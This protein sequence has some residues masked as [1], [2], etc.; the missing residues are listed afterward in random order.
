M[1]NGNLTA[2]SPQN[3]SELFATFFE[4]VYDDDD[5][6]GRID[7]SVTSNGGFSTLSFSISDIETALAGLDVSKGPGDDGIPPSFIKRCADG[8]K[9]PLLHIFNLSLSKGLFP[10]KWKDSYLIPIFKSGKRNEVGN[11]RGVAILSCFA[12]LFEVITYGYIFFAIK[13]SLPTNQHGFVSGRSTVTNLIEFTSFVLNSMESGCQVDSIYTDFSKAFDK[14]NHRL[15]LLKLTCLGF[16]GNFLNWIASYLTGRCQYVKIGN[17]RSRLFPVKSGVPQGSHLGPLLFI[18]FLY[19]VN[20]CFKSVRFL[21]YADD[22]KIYFQVRNSSDYIRAQTELDKFSQW[23]S[24]N[25]MSLNLSKC[26]TI[27]F[28]RSTTVHN[29]DYRLSGS[30]LDR[31]ETITDL[32][33]VLDTKLTFSSHVDAIV[34]K[35]S[36]RLGFIK[37]IGK[38]FRD[39]Y[40][41]KT[42]FNSYVRSKLE[43]ASVIWNPYYRTHSDRIESVQRRFMRFALRFLRWNNNSPLPPYCQ[44]CRLID[45]E[46]LNVRRRVACV[47]FVHDVLSNKYDC[48]VVL[49]NMSFL[50]YRRNVRSRVMFREDQH[51]TNYGANEPLNGAIRVF[52]RFSNIYEHG[53][54]RGGFRNEVRRTLLSDPC[55]CC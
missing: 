55:T 51:R 18:L 45:V 48:P 43:Y 35:A 37:R 42:L 30:T 28:T 33:V 23:C 19:D 11:Y 1:K 32:G 21:L 41:L 54:G 34:N 53:G 16:G 10:S 12:K 29:F 6:G 38:E 49:S 15:L 3:V 24:D 40:A 27:S 52:N 2:D 14:V 39:V 7:G 47:M 4:S 9:S 8:L 13:S 50:V 46:R 26:K 44:R 22:L 31:V 36:K 17:S 5:G 25:K 20:V